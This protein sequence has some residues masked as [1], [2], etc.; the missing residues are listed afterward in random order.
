MLRLEAD[1]NNKRSD[2]VN[3]AMFDKNA[4]VKLIVPSSVDLMNE[5]DVLNMML[6]LGVNPSS[7]E[8][9]LFLKRFG[10]GRNVLASKVED[11]LTNNGKKLTSVPAV[12]QVV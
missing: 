12:E 9:R 3:S 10:D 1:W 6:G 11:L 8:L 5:D 4:V 7:Q 2:M